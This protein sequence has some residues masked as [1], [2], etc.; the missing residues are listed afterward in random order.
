MIESLSLTEGLRRLSI[1]RITYCVVAALPIAISLSLLANP[2]LTHED[3][4]TS[5]VL[6]LLLP[7]LDIPII[8][9]GIAILI[10][11]K[12]KREPLLFWSVA[13]F[14][15]ST[16]IIALVGIMATTDPSSFKIP[17]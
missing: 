2:R 4:L 16:P 9:V 6:S 17:Q 10:G 1:G 8:L 12:I 15:A 14:I 13:V 3:Q 7:I 5:G 11:K